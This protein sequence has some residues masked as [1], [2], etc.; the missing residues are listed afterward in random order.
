MY[1]C[2]VDKTHRCSWA[3][4]VPSLETSVDNLLMDAAVYCP[5]LEER[6]RSYQQKWKEEQ[7]KQL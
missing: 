3:A 2:H 7:E 6:N 5:V 1:V 4:L